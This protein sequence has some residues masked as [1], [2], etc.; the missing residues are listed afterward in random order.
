MTT[1]TV[2]NILAIGAAFTWLLSDSKR[3]RD[4][5][6]ARPLT[7]AIYPAAKEKLLSGGLDL[8]RDEVRVSLESEMPLEGGRC[9]TV[10]VGPSQ[11]LRNVTVK[12]GVL[13]ADPTVF[14]DVSGPP[15]TGIQLGMSDGTP[16][17]WIREGEPITPTGGKVTIDWDTHGI[18]SL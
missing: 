8:T 6:T 10:A 12:D 3:K 14:P 4:I 16:L 11:V 2:R 15:I 9:L 7:S 13:R 5:P 18:F 17:A 1:L